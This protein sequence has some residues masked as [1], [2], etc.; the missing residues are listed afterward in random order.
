MTYFLAYRF[1][2]IFGLL[3]CHR[4]NQHFKIHNIFITEQYGFRKGLCTINATH[5]L[6]EIILNTWNN[7]R[8]IAGVFCDL[9][10]AFD[11]VN[12]DY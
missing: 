2:K 7:N 8:Y 11:C 12:H 5:K 10:K 1:S 9:T 4:I 3:I 6:T